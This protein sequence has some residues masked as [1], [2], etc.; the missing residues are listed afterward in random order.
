MPDFFALDFFGAAGTFAPFFLAS[1]KPIAI[2]CFGLVTFFP[3][4]P[5]RSL[6]CFIS[7]ISRSTDLEALGLYFLPADLRDDFL[8]AFLAAGILLTSLDWEAIAASRVVSSFP[9]TTAGTRR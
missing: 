5:E 9:Q 4:R 2:A 6:P 7:F 8:L 3:L 1:D